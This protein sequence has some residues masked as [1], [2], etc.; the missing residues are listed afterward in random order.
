M[1]VNTLETR[2]TGADRSKVAAAEE[3]AVGAAS[4]KRCSE[5]KRGAGEELVS[6]E[7]GGAPGQPV[8][9]MEAELA[10]RRHLQGR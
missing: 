7:V 9:K 8:G 3:A 1:R 10:S 6:H 5:W 2:S 4:L